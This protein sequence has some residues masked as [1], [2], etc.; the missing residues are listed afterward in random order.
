MAGP[1][2][3]ST[4]RTLATALTGTWRRLVLWG[5]AF[6]ILFQ[7]LMLAALVL[8]FQA[9]PNYVTFF[10]WPGNVATIIRSTPSWS[11]IPPIIAEEWL[12]ELGRM[13]YDY[14]TGISEWSLNVVPSRMAVLFVLGALVGLAV[15][16]MRAEA[17]DRTTARS[18]MATTGLGAGLVAM[19]NVTLSWVVCCATPNWVVGLSMM[20]LGVSTSLALER[21]GPA[22]GLAGFSLLALIILFLAWRKAHPRDA[23]YPEPFHA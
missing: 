9:L 10:D 4:A 16:L 1:D 6:A 19:T 23:A 20:G 21:M 12:I 17:C 18:S 8:R 13:N 3:M 5:L 14:G 11:D 7:V 22:L 2:A 15:T